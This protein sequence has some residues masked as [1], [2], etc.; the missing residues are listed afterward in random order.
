MNNQERYNQQKNRLSTLT[1][2][3]SLGLDFIKH[4]VEAQTGKTVKSITPM[5]VLGK[6][7]DYSLDNR[8]FFCVIHDHVSA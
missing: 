4:L 3:S 6:S 7:A 5:Q 1:D 2:D 8:A